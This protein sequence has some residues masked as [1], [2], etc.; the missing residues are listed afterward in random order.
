[1]I[2]TQVQSKLAMGMTVVA[3]S[4]LLLGCDQQSA[5]S[6]EKLN[7]EWRDASTPQDSSSLVSSYAPTRGGSSNPAAEAIEQVTGGGSR[8]AAQTT[9]GGGEGWGQSRSDQAQQIARSDDARSGYC[10]K[11]VANILSR[12]GYP[13]TRGHARDWDQTLP[14]NGW[15]RANCNASNPSTCPPGTV[16]QFEPDNPPSDRSGGARYGHVEIVVRTSGGQTLYCSDACR[17]NFGGTV[18]RNRPTAWVYNR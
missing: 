7:P 16:L 9:G 5:G 13:V 15:T 4:L 3:M 14:R 11:G 2:T 17:S 10:A 12:M 1:M 18:P 6:Q 8:P